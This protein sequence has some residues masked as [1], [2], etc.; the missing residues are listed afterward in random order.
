MKIARP[1]R[2]WRRGGSIMATLGAF[3][4]CTPL[5]ADVFRPAYLELQQRGPETFDVLWKVPA[6][7]ESLRLGIHVVFPEGTTNVTEPRGTFTS[8]A[9]VERWTIQ[10]TG[11]L[12]GFE[13][14]IDGLPASITDVLARVVRTN[15]ITQVARLLPG[16][17]QFV[18]ESI[19]DGA[20]L[21]RTYLV[22]GIE[23][24]LTGFDHLLFLL[25]LVLIVDDRRRL[26]WT[27]TAFTI[28]HSFTLAAATLGFVHVA[29]APVEAA[30]ALSI[31]FVAAELV[32][33]MQ[34]RLG[35]TARAPWIVAFSFGLLHGLGFA[36]ALAQ[37][38]LPPNSIP[39]ALL[40]FNVGVEL[41]Q[42]AFVIAVWAALAAL[43]RLRI[44]QPFWARAMAPYAIGSVA[45]FW[46]IQRIDAFLE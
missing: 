31:V 14:R 1:K 8:D 19:R 10:R 20:G 34:G 35:V 26:L 21:V 37:V 4:V 6:Q 29:Q 42:L 38:G 39:L 30:I 23:H 36:G 28:A 3:V 11:G 44:P 32:H 9:F 43:L 5:L 15:G 16:R 13:I 46:M 7:S 12:E 25:A 17:P 45:M 41:G 2:I 18:V 24:I 27:I 22:L 40:F 33:G